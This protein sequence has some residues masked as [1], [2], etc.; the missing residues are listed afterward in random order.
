M[1]KQEQPSRERIVSAAVA[2]ADADGLAAVTMRRVGAALDREAMS[3]YYY[4]PSKADLLTALVEDVLTA[5]ATESARI[6]RDDWRDTVRERCLAA[7]AVMLR[8]PWAPGLV[9]AQQHPPAAAL[10]VFELLVGTLTAAGFT[11]ELSHRA[12]H[13]LGSLLF[14]FSTELFEP[15]AA[16]DDDMEDAAMLV[17]AEHLP[18]LAR[19]AATVIHET[20]GALSTCDTESE[21]VFTLDLLL[22]GLENARRDAA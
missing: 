3:L 7:R 5:V 17:T 14:G 15:D 6:E 20:D 9:M 1:S 4:V 11:D 21:F 16:A 22:D 8:H 10:P 12:V 2:I 18:H 19:M 13:S